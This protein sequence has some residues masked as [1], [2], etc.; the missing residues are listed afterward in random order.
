MYPVDGLPTRP[1][2]LEF[3]AGQ[4][5]GKYVPYFLKYNPC[6]TCSH[7]E[8][9]SKASNFSVIETVNRIGT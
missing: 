3:M 6:S 9:I 8:S 1:G 7:S 5:L 4:M 2:C